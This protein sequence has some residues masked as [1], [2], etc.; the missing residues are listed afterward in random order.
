MSWPDSHGATY[1]KI[2]HGALSLGEAH[3]LDAGADDARIWSRSCISHLTRE[4][5]IDR[6][7]EF[8]ADRNATAQMELEIAVFPHTEKFNWIGVAKVYPETK[9]RDV[10]DRALPPEV[11]LIL[12]MA[13]AIPKGRL[14]F[15]PSAVLHGPVSRYGAA[16]IGEGHASLNQCRSRSR[17]S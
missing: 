10:D 13:K 2:D 17:S 12:D 8:K 7:T 1:E 4:G 3:E 9:R 6:R 11:R 15:L 5:H 14:A 16:S